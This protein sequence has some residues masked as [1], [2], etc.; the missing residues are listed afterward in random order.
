MDHNDIKQAAQ[1]RM[2]MGADRYGEFDPLKDKRD[3]IQEAIDEGLDKYNYLSMYKRQV[4]VQS[5]Q[6]GIAIDDWLDIEDRIDQ[7]CD[8][9]LFNLQCL[10]DLQEK[11]N[12]IGLIAHDELIEFITNGRGFSLNRREEYTKPL[13]EKEG[14]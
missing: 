7:M 4:R 10:Y 5:R 6:A 12:A 14:A 11:V 9:E 2:D 3:L 8:L 13:V 1:V